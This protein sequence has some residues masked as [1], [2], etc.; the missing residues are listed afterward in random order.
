MKVLLQHPP[1]IDEI[2]A[3]FGSRSKPGI[4]YAYGDAIYNPSGAP[5]TPWLLA[6]ELTHILNQ[7]GDPDAWWRKYI[8]DVEY[9]YNEELLA[10]RAEMRTRLQGVRDR[11]ARIKLVMETAA[12]LSNPLYKTGRG[13]LKAKKDL[14]S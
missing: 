10:H 12:R 9:R 4:L 7:A 13:L 1:N 5:L 11:N 8:E 3:A 6:H 14:E 2:D